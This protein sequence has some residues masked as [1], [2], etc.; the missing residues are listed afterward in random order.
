MRR[1]LVVA[2]FLG[3]A[4]GSLALL[5]GTAHA[6][7][8]VIS[9]QGCGLFDGD[10]NIVLA[11]SDHSVITPSGNGNCNLKCS[12]KGVA[13]SSGRAVNLDSTIV[14]ISCGIPGCAPTANWHETISASGNATLTC[15]VPE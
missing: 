10:G 4:A 11:S 9:D 15:L 6:Q 8:V 5:R 12:V 7:A 13:N 2:A 1:L 3:L 14:P